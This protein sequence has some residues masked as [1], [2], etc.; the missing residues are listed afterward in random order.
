M[1]DQQR[2]DIAHLY[3]Q[4]P[5]GVLFTLVESHDAAYIPGARMYVV[6]ANRAG[7]HF[8]EELVSHPVL[9]VA[10]HMHGDVL[11]ELGST[12]EAEAL[13]EACLAALGGEL[14]VVST[15]LPEGE[16][17]LLRFVMDERG[18][19]LFASELLETEDIVPL[20]RFARTSE[21]GVIHVSSQGRLFVERMEPV[22]ME[23]RIIQNDVPHAEAE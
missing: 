7:I 23:E 17:P 22:V 18:D 20:R 4:A 21:H 9:P 3:R 15:L 5:H 12:S 14:R 13:M 2:R 19:V 11:M 8:A 10:A 6:D 16:T 1:T